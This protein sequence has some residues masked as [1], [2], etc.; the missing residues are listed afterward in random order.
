MQNRNRILCTALLMFAV[1][2]LG[3]KVVSIDAA[4]GMVTVDHEAIPGFMDAMTMPYKLKDASVIP[5]R[6]SAANGFS[7][8]VINDRLSRR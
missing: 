6:G 2:L 5:A 8:I 7:Q 3:G 1:T 4:S